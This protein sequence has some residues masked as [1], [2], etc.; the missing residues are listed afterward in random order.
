MDKKK[1]RGRIESLMGKIFILC[2]LLVMAVNLVLPDKEK[3]DEENRML[4]SM[5]RLSLTSVMTGDF[6]EQWENYMSDQFFGVA[7]AQSGIRPFGREQYG[8]RYLHW[9]E[10]T[11]S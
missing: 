1:K 10:R 7:E 6:M 5:P 11:A 3:S 8:E 9:K 2:L 4:T